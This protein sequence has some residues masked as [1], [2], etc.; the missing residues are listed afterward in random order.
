MRFGCFGILRDRVYYSTN[1]ISNKLVTQRK[2]I[3]NIT[4]KT[5]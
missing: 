2:I 4:P 5:K 1:E 3:E